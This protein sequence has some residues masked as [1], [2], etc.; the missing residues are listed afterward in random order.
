MGTWIGIEESKKMLSSYPELQQLHELAISHYGESRVSLNSLNGP[1]KDISEC[2]QLWIHYPKITIENSNGNKRILRDIYVRYKINKLGR[3]QNG[4]R[5]TR[6]T[7]TYE[8][9]LAGYVHSHLPGISQDVHNDER[10]HNYGD[11][12]YGSGPIL[13]ILSSLN[14]S[15]KSNYWKL[16][17]LQMDAYLAWESLEGG[18]Y[19]MLSRIRS[20]ALSNFNRLYREGGANRFRRDNSVI[21]HLDPWSKDTI[22]KNLLG[23][24]TGLY[25]G[26]ENSITSPNSWR[27]L[28]TRLDGSN[29]LGVLD[30]I[31]RSRG[32]YDAENLHHLIVFYLVKE[33]L[34]SSKLRFVVRTIDFPGNS[35]P[36]PTIVLGYTFEEMEYLIAHTELFRYLAQFGIDKPDFE[37]N[38]SL[39]F[40]KFNDRKERMSQAEYC[41]LTTQQEE[42]G[43]II[44]KLLN[45]STQPLLEF[46]GKPV[47]INV[48]SGKVTFDTSHRA[49]TNCVGNSPLV[50]HSQITTLII[51]IIIRYVN[52]IC[53][54]EGGNSRFSDLQGT[55]EE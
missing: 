53:W 40:R 42:S 50:P 17:F 28:L 30:L 51:S 46:R 16:C 14:D 23:A 15:Y 47:T 31:R 5:F 7:Y 24:S 20:Q 1:D 4:P 37:L 48:I 6:S 55:N 33:L 8:E 52:R 44:P 19:K 26:L 45:I 35:N 29:N 54:K 41:Y 32:G 27:T 22:Y 43:E 10:F 39:F 36:V 9:A 12:C 49:E 13:G 34:E 2:L 3:L 18:P 21:V 25:Q 11:A 38:R